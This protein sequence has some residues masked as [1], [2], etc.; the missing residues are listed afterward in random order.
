MTFAFA[1]TTRGFRW[2]DLPPLLADTAATTGM[3]YLVIVGAAVFGTF[4][5]LTTLPSAAIAAIEAM[6]LPPLAVI[7]AL[8]AMYLV[9]GAVFDTIGAMVL[10]L[11]FVFP[12]VTGLGF[13]PVWWGIVNVMM[14]EIGL[15]TP[16]IGMNVFVL[17]GM[18]PRIPLATIFRGVVPFVAADLVRVVLL[19]LVPA[20]VTWLPGVLN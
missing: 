8:L 18:A 9:L 6:N 3:I 17:H 14:I 16:P 15:V 2:R 10:T 12:L 20:L 1:L 5:S 7:F 4:M 13:D 19:I 11:P